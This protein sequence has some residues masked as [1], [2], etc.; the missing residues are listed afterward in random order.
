MEKEKVDKISGWEINIISVLAFL[1]GMAFRAGIANLNEP[2]GFWLG[3][4]FM[5]FVMVWAN[6]MRQAYNM[7]KKE[8]KERDTSLND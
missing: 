8:R 7:I 5:T 3:I 6:E 2:Y 4:S 1:A